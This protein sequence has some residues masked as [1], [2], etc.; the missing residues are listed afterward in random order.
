VAGGRNAVLAHWHAPC[1][2][3]LRRHLLAREDA[4]MAGLCPLAQLEFD[5]L[6]LRICR[7]LG[8]AGRIEASVRRPA[9]EIAAADFPDEVATMFSMIRADTPCP[10][11]M[12]EAAEPRALVQRADCI[13]TERAK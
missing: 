5:Q 3:N 6:D 8:E 4:A 13:G 1:R 9:A 2:G 10:G 11:I 7:L 12:C